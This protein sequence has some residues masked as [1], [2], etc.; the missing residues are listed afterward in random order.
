MSKTITRKEILEQ[1][2]TLRLKFQSF[3]RDYYIFEAKDP[4]QNDV[5]MFLRFD[6]IRAANSDSFL[7]VGDFAHL[8]KKFV[9][10]LILSPEMEI[11]YQD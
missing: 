9:R 6:A 3:C 11:V 2:G 7:Y 4:F 1:L 8:D 5:T 10:F